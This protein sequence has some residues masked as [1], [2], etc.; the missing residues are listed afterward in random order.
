M[1]A[2]KIKNRVTMENL[3]FLSAGAAARARKVPIPAGANSAEDDEEIKAAIEAGAKLY[4]KLAGLLDEEEEERV[5]RL[6]AG[7]SFGRKLSF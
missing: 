3:E 2:D 7:A 4:E 6:L 1:S 5:S